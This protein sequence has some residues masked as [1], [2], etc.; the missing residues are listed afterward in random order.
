MDQRLTFFAVI[1]LA[2]GGY[3]ESEKIENCCTYREREREPGQTLS[4]E[5]GWIHDCV[6]VLCTHL[7]TSL[8]EH[9]IVIGGIRTH[10]HWRK[11]WTPVPCGV[12]VRDLTVCLRRGCGK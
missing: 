2:L 5:P 1:R 6:F 7:E 8:Q 12:R 3:Q 10:V 4:H 9:D 11:E